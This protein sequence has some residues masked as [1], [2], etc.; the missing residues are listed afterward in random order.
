MSGNNTSRVFEIGADVNANISGLTIEDG[1]SAG[2]GGGIENFGTLMLSNSIV[3]DNLAHVGSDDD[4]GYGGGICNFATLTVTDTT[5]SDNTGA[6][7]G[8]IFNQSVATISNSTVSGNSAL[9]W[10]GGIADYNTLTATNCTVSANTAY[11]SGGGLYVALGDTNTPVMLIN[12]TVADNHSNDPGAA[13]PPGQGGGIFIDPS[14]GSL[15]RLNNTIVAGNFNG[16]SSTRSDDIQGMVDGSSAYNL[17]G[18]G[19]SG[20]LGDTNHNQVGWSNPGLA[21]LADYGGPTSTMALLPSSPA[22]SLGSVSLANA[23]GLTTDQRGFSRFDDNGRVDIGAFE[24]TPGTYTA[25]NLGAN[26]AAGSFLYYF[27]LDEQLDL[28]SQIVFTATSDADVTQFLSQ[29]DQLGQDGPALPPGL[30]IPVSLYLPPNATLSE[31][32]LGP[33]TGVTQ[34]IIGDGSQYVFGGSPALTVA[35]GNVIVSGVNFTQASDAPALLITGGSLALR[36]DTVQQNSGTGQPAIELTGGDVDLGT[37]ADP[38]AN[39]VNLTGSNPLL[40]NTSSGPVVAA[41]DTFFANGTPLTVPQAANYAFEVNENSSLSVAG[42]GL[43]ANDFDPNGSPLSAVVA[44]GPSDGMLTLDPGGFFTYTPK[45]NFAG[46]DSFTYQAKADDGTFS[47]PATVTLYVNVVASQFVISGLPSATDLNVAQSFTVAAEDSSGRTAASYTGTIHFTSSDSQASLPADFTFTASDLGTYTFTPGAAF[48]TA[49]TQTLMA[50]DATSPAITGS[51]SL[52]VN[53]NIVIWTGA[54]GNNE[55]DDPNNW[56]DPLGNNRLPGP[57]DEAI[58]NQAGVTVYHDENMNDAVFSVQSQAAIVVS[59]GSLTMAGS[60]TFNSTL[61]LEGGTLGGAGDITVNGQFTWDGGMLAGTGNVYLNGGTAANPNIAAGSTLTLDRPLV[62]NGYT[63]IGAGIYVATGVTMTNA[64]GATLESEDDSAILPL[65]GATGEQFIN[66]GTF[67]RTT[68]GS[69]AQYNY[70]S[71]PFNNGSTG[72]VQ[73]EANSIYFYGGGSSS[74]AW[75]A[76]PGTVLDFGSQFSFAAATPATPNSSITAGAGAEVAFDG[77]GAV[78]IACPYVVPGST[79]ISYGSV[80][81]FTGPVDVAGSDLLFFVNVGG[82]ADFTSATLLS[83]LTFREVVGGQNTMLLSNADIHITGTFYEPNGSVTFGGSGT[84]CFD[85]GTAADPNI[86]ANTLT[87]DRPLVSNGYTVI[88]AG[89]YLATGVTMTNAAG[90]TLESYDDSAI[91]PLAGATGEQFINNG[92]FLRTTDGSPA[93]YNYISVPFNNGSTG[94]VNVEANAI[95]FYDGGSSSG[96]WAADPGTELD[97]GSSF[98][99]AAAT[100]ATPNSSITGGAGALIAFDGP[101][102]VTI[103]CPYV[104]PGSTEIDYG[105]EVQFT[106]PVNV[107]GSDLLVVFGGTADFTAAT[108]LSPLTFDNVTMSSFIGN[109]TLVSNADIHVTGVLACSIG[110]LAGTGTVYLDGGTST[111]PNYC[112]NMLTLDRPLVNNCYARMSGDVYLGSGAT[113]TNAAGATW[114]SQD[115]AVVEPQSGAS[116]EGFINNGTFLKTA[117]V[118]IPYYSQVAVPFTNGPTGIVNVEANAIYFYD[119]G[120]SSGAWAADPGTEL[121]FGSSFSFAAAT[122]ATPNSSITGGA[123]ALIAFDGPG[124]VTI[125]CPYVVPGSTEIDYGAEVQFTGPVNVQGSDLLVVFGGTADFTAATLL[126]P[127]TFDNVTMSSFIGNATLVSNADIHVTGVLACSIGTLAG[128]GTVYLDGGTSTTPNYCNNML[129][130]DRPLVNNGYTLLG[131]DTYLGSGVTLTNAVG[132]TLVNLLA[133]PLAGASGEEFINNGTFLSQGYDYF[134]AVPFINGPTGIVHV[135]SNSLSFTGGGSSSGAWVADPGTVLDFGV[136]AVTLTPICSITADSLDLEPATLTV[137]IS[138]PTPG[139]GLPSIT[140][141][142]TAAIGGQLNLDLRNGFAPSLGE[143]FTLINNQGSAPINGTFDG[144]PE[145]ATVRSGPYGFTI[146]YAG[147][148]SGN[149]VV[150]TLSQIQQYPTAVAVSSD[151]PSGSVYGQMVTFTASVSATPAPSVTAT[152]SVQF[153]VDGSDYGTPVSLVGGTGSVMAS[154][155]AGSHGVT[156]D[157]TSDSPSFANSDSAPFTALVSPATLSVTANNATKVYGQANPSFTDTITGFVNG[158]PPSVVSGSANLSTT[159]TP[160]SRPGNYTITAV[161]GTLS[162]ANYAFAFVNGALTVLKANPVI[163]WSSPSPI[164]VTTPLSSTQLDATANVQGTFAY[165]PGP[166][167]LLPAGTQI[168]SVAFTPTD[169]TDYTTATATVTINVL[170]RQS[171]VYVSTAYAG[172]A[173]APS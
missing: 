138:G 50:T 19:G 41:G 16:A 12:V 150:L 151:H 76:D 147:G 63:V 53:P 116:G 69:P 104:V 26:T 62:N 132:A 108:L 42:P 110:T 82:T 59:G 97:F 165:N 40:L 158:D 154:L 70:I 79:E 25:T 57:G 66:N 121:D 86:V 126:S 55:W 89:I 128:T 92:T 124:T 164:G 111:T 157:Y 72:I 15:P 88:G 90:A 112:N 125:A 9:V 4:Y 120:S 93:Q 139:A 144:L 84:V 118:S 170:P 38:G 160:T 30:Q 7:G 58:I 98:S 109:A 167:E 60:S 24:R 103:A 8:G 44:S 37:A 1:N 117:T 114:E 3:S 77:A 18:T 71:V 20:G 146:T 131:A 27:N 47:S 95:Y 153:L 171:S 32:N 101:G 156:A 119:G 48:A 33:P 34:S 162:A 166:G 2:A 49:G 159:A 127:L 96:A 129:T 75:V 145:G 172:G 87:L 91:L 21:P 36:D 99:F 67:L 161:Q 29:I 169:T 130:L 80:V 141:T 23:A 11:A 83:P 46:T 136:G 17:I 102:T 163:T 64:A 51:A 106:G 122:P 54:D 173:P 113:V 61:Q 35:S 68:D 74:G 115:D 135:E 28:G 65:A 52:F 39:T 152:G 78:T 81:Q 14:S 43:L 133:L 148:A 107:Q 85:G 56:L 73:L 137:Q 100:P 45:A 168:L 155:P 142:N 10:G 123:G 149:S 134:V 105:A 13:V 94:I 140:V 5:V 22:I 143:A 31:F 6:E